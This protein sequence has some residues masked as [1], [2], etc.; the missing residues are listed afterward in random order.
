MSFGFFVALILVGTWALLP[1]SMVIAM[2]SFDDE[3]MSDPHDH[4]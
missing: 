1:L 2:T 4:H 3:A